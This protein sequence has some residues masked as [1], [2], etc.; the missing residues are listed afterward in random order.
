MPASN[1][2]SR[3]SRS[4]R[5]LSAP[6]TVAAGLLDA[7]P[8]ATCVL[9]RDG[10]IIAVNRA[11]QMF[12]LDNGGDPRTTGVGVSYLDVCERAAAAT[13]ED[14]GHVAAGLREVLAGQTVESDYE[15]PCP[16]P[17]VGRWFVLRMTPMLRPDPCLLVSHTNITRRKAA[18]LDLEARASR[19]PLTGLGNRQ[20]LVEQLAK[21]LTVRPFRSASPD[22]GVLY[23]DLDGF[24]SV[25]DTYGHAAGD[26]VLQE[27][28]RRLTLATRPQDTVVR[29]G[30]DEFAVVASR[31]TPGGQA[32]LVARIRADLLVPHLI[33]G[34]LVGVGA[35]VGSYL[36]TAGED[37]RACLE[38][39]DQSMY[40]EKRSPART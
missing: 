36:A 38:T 5:E 10:V 22:V 24:K 17:A 14:A 40:A 19:D 21:A 25:N 8:D 31:I 11:W 18:E 7:L 2:T 23:L 35:S 32:G 28:A 1:R 37:P 6:G 4:G 29:M 39:A 15:Y 26:E 30:G 20:M 3:S 16:S 33:H 13:C 9:D 27:V 12:T 34:H